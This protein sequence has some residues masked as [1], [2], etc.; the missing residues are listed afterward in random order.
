MR[1][2]FT[3]D[4]GDVEQEF[5]AGFTCRVLLHDCKIHADE[6]KHGKQRYSPRQLSFPPP[7]EF[8]QISVCL[9]APAAKFKNARMTI[10]FS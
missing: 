10:S 3:G 8:S 1:V 9:L 5:E 7:T 4:S 6:V 2:V